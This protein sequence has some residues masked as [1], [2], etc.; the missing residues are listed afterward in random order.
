MV[1][2]TSDITTKRLKK[3]IDIFV[4]FLWK[5][6]SSSIKSSTLTSCLKSA[7]VTPL[8]RKG[9]IDKTDNYIFLKKLMF[10]QM[11]AYF[12]KIFSKYQYGFRKGYNTA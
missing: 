9:K 3:N 6:I 8:H 11:Y 10:S 5:R 7:D 1:S 4:E 2:Q 12:D